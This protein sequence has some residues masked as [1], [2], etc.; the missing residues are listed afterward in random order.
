MD[1]TVVKNHEATASGTS[2]S[3]WFGIQV[4]RDRIITD[5]KKSLMS[6]FNGDLRLSYHE[7]VTVS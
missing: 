1:K 4:Y 2:Y 7:N 3:L 6:N 5:R